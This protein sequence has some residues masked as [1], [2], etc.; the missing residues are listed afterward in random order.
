MSDEMKKEEEENGGAALFSPQ[1]KAMIR[2]RNKY[3]K[4]RRMDIGSG[5]KASVVRLGAQHPPGPEIFTFDKE[6]SHGSPHRRK[7]KRRSRVLFPNDSRKFMP[8]NREYSRA[9]P[10][11]ALFSI[12]VFLQVYNAIENLD[13]HVLKYDL[14]GLER[15]LS[16]EVYGQ[17]AALE[18]L[19]GHLRDYLSTYV[20]QQPLLLSIHGPSG[21]GKSHLGH[22]LA[23]HFRSVVGEGL[24][25]QY[26]S[27][28]SCPL[29][30]DPENCASE[31]ASRITEV[32]KVAEEEERIP[33]FIL[34]E[35]E[36]MRTPSLEVL[37]TLI[38][39]EQDNEFQNAVYVLLSNLGQK[40]VIAHILQNFT[41]AGAARLLRP[42]LTQHHALWSD[43][44]VEVLALSLLEQKHVIQCFLEEMTREGFYPDQSH[45]ERLAGEISYYSVAGRQYSQ[46]GCKQV[47][48][49]VNML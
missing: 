4:R 31:L 21:V 13:D 12:I 40:E 47:V 18:E 11:L 36:A 19:M 38:Q 33:I 42:I 48:A 39:P 5:H 34:D 28:H 29:E 32:V 45:V 7:K 10:F 15:T 3:L 43:G 9:K 23:R 14:D 22:V 25:V 1:L 26:F 24:V 2:I 46:S 41:A 37:R 30:G 35:V 27:L 44:K 20:H 8:K 49:K 17:Q 6:N 16:R